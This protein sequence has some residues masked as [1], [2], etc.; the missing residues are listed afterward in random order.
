MVTG[1]VC[2]VIFMYGVRRAKIENGILNGETW[3]ARVWTLEGQRCHLTEPY[4]SFSFFWWWWRCGWG[5][6]PGACV[7]GQTFSGW[8]VWNWK[9]T[10]VVIRVLLM[11]NFS[12]S[13]SRKSLIFLSYLYYSLFSLFSFSKLEEK[14]KKNEKRRS[15]IKE[16]K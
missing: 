8:V 4:F 14:K 6:V 3:C 16:R 1:F 11:S 12:L 15:V 2:F 13:R 7:S 5:P 9:E 10:L